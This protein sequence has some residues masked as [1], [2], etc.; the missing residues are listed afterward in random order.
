MS[1]YATLAEVKQHLRYDDESND[2]ILQGFLA[3]A[4]TAIN[5]YITDTVTDDM[6]P[7]LKVATLLLVGN[8]DEDRNA[9]KEKSNDDNYL[10]PAVRRLLY[11]YRKPTAVFGVI[12]ASQ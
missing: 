9:G 8:F 7:A 2:L 11:P 5:N 6:L 10:P 4:E 3:G 12:D 1:K